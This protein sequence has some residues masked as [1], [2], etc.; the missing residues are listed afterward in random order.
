MKAI[1][2]GAHTAAFAADRWRRFTQRPILDGQQN[3][4]AL[5]ALRVITFL[6]ALTAA[7][8]SHA[9]EPLAES[10]GWYRGKR[11]GMPP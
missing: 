7:L 8:A 5:I 10:P 3:R 9:A 2:W 11:L 4:Y 1:L 6:L